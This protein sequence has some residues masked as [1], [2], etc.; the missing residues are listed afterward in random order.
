MYVGGLVGYNSGGEINNSYAS[1]AASGEYAVGGLIGYSTFGKII[2]SYSL[3][4]VNRSYHY[5]EG[6]GGL[7]GEDYEGIITNSFYDSETTG[8]S[9][10]AGGTGKSSDVMKDRDTYE[11]DSANA[12]G[13]L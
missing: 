12:W 5:S 11:E 3:G 9:V 7:I 6:L 1:A 4:A 13:F 8:Q 2:N 10:S